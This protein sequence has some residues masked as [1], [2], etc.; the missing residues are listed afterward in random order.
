MIAAKFYDDVSFSNKFYAKVGGITPNE[1]NQLE[2]E[3]LYNSNFNLNVSAELFLAY[4]ENL[5]QK[6]YI[7]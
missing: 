2:I 1:L 6:N 3:M 4:R 5:L 7:D